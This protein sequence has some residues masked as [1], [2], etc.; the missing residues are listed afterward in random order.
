MF[1][2]VTFQFQTAHAT[3][4]VKVRVY[5]H[6]VKGIWAS[7][8]TTTDEWPQGATGLIVVND[9]ALAAGIASIPD[10]ITNGD[11]PWYVWQGLETHFVTATEIGVIEVAGQQFTID[12][13]AMRKVGSNEDVAVVAVNAHA[14]QGARIG[15]VGRML[16]KTH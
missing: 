7:D 10:P 14:T 4:L 1:V 6:G 8:Q 12:S 9:Q 2:K 11:A 16:I 3:Y 15:L 13:K 5:T